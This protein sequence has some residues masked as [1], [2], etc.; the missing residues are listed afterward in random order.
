MSSK[1]LAEWFKAEGS[2]GMSQ[3]SRAVRADEKRWLSCQG[4][5]TVGV[6]DVTKSLKLKNF[7]EDVSEDTVRKA[8]HSGDLPH[9]K[10]ESLYEPFRIDVNSRPPID[11]NVDLRTIPEIAQ[12][13]GISERHTRR[14]IKDSKSGFPFDRFL[15]VYYSCVN[16]IQAWKKK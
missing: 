4:R 11:P 9:E 14:L 5:F 2:K 3:K 16:S 12:E 7:P 15:G 1:F 13:A 10:R 6:P 8:F